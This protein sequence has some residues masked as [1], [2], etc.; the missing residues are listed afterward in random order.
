MDNAW[1]IDRAW[2]L[3]RAHAGWGPQGDA[4]SGCTTHLHGRDDPGSGPRPASSAGSPDQVA[5]F[6]ATQPPPWRW[7]HLEWQGGAA[8]RSP[9]E[10]DRTWDRSLRGTCVDCWPRSS[11]ALARWRQPLLRQPRRLHPRRRS[12]GPAARGGLRYNQFH[13]TALCSPT[14][15]ALL[16]GRNHHTN[17]MGAVTEMATSFPGNT[18]VRPDSVAPLAEMLRLNGY[19][20]ELLREEPRDPDLGD[21]PLGPDH[22]LAEPV[23]LRRVLR[24]HGRGD[25]PVGAARLPQPGAGRDPQGPEVPLHERHDEPG[26]RLDAVPEG[27]DAGSAVLH[28][29]RA[30]RHPRAAPRPEGVDRE[31][32]GQVRQGLGRHAGGGAGPPDPARRGAAGHPARPQAGSHQGLGQAL[33]RRE[34]ALRPPDGGLRRLR[35]VRGRGDRPARRRAPG[36]RAVRRHAR[37]STSWAT[38]ARAPRAA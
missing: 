17:N 19:S 31:V 1:S 21:Q 14:R 23:R 26:H 37:S 38:T 30:R 24:I 7:F 12:T 35:R 10:G 22:A 27:A 16:S 5:P 8:K 28:V 36:D 33:G 15:T 18:G 2:S 9:F 6:G 11:W 34:E 4:A 20:T 32:Q 29:L 13:T 25:Q 3:P